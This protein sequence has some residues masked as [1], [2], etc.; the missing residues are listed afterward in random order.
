MNSRSRPIKEG[1]FT[2]DNFASHFIR[3]QIFH[4]KYFI[5]LKYFILFASKYLILYLKGTKWT[6]LNQLNKENK[7]KL[8]SWTLDLNSL[9]RA[10]FS[11][12]SILSPC[13]KSTS[14][15]DVYCPFRRRYSSRLEDA[16]CWWPWTTAEPPF[17]LFWTLTMILAIFAFWKSNFLFQNLGHNHLKKCKISC[18]GGLL[19]EKQ[20]STFDNFVYFS[21]SYW[22][23]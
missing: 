21:K 5:Y 23:S 14:E 20:A 8:N 1:Q 17:D 10:F 4:F 12:W 7:D 9:F 11:A 2:F 22:P 6:L 16:A 19:N 3:V 15:H 13:Q 18:L